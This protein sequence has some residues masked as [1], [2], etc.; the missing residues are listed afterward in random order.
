M[1][2][3]NKVGKSEGEGGILGMVLEF[4]E[5]VLSQVTQVTWQRGS[6]SRGEDGEGDEVPWSSGVAGNEGSLGTPDCVLSCLEAVQR[7][8]T[9]SSVQADSGLQV[10]ATFFWILRLFFSYNK[11]L[12]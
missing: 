9:L 12:A 7:T 11:M 2:I 3:T 5:S 8:T 6:S 1:T 10:K 4:L